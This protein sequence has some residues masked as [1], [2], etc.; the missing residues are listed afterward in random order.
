MVESN[1]Q[2]IIPDPASTPDAA[3][4]PTAAKQRFRIS[5]DV[6]ART[7]ANLPEDQA[8]AVRW[9]AGY[10]RTRNIPLEEAAALLIKPNGGAYAGASVYAALTGLRTEQGISVERFTEAIEVFRRKVETPSRVGDSGFIATRLSKAVF[11]R[12]D[13][14]RELHK[15]GFIFGE[16]QIGKTESLLEY[17][18]THNHGETVYLE[19]P[20]KPTLHQVR[21]LLA[22]V[23][24]IPDYH[25]SGQVDRA[26]FRA[27][28][29]NILLIVDEAHNCFHNQSGWLVFGF[30]KNLFNS[31]G[32][33][34]MISMTNEGKTHLLKGAH[35]HSLRQ[36]WRRRL[37]P[38]HLPDVLPVDDLDRFS[39]AY[40]LPPAPGEI[41][42]VRIPYIDDETGQ[43]A[44]KLIAEVPFDLQ[45]R[46]NAQEGLG[47]WLTILQKAKRIAKAAGPTVTITWG[48][49][50]KAHCINQA[51]A[52]I[53]Q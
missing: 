42:R 9:Y 18:R 10:C 39:A 45:T 20:E 50:I 30:L 12:C 8:K 24:A 27:L 5:A 28:H 29:R 16:S 4:D 3:P 15:I 32:C 21:T 2:L 33:G 51:D 14:T 35:A 31:C 48:A 37:T 7:V 38:L 22:Q 44:E 19:I 41:V 25:S 17:Q 36:L 49:V 23:L 34:I 11:E 47:V 26:I 6:V 1:S 53:W 13:E 46:V 52:E 43:R 40:K